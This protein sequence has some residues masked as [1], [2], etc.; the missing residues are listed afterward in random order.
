[1]TRL[2]LLASRLKPPAHQSPETEATASPLRVTP[3]P[4]LND[5]FSNQFVNLVEREKKQRV[6]VIYIVRPFFSEK[7]VSTVVGCL[8]QVCKDQGR[9]ISS[10]VAAATV[11]S[12]VFVHTWWT[13]A[14]NRKTSSHYH[15]ITA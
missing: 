13:I 8:H 3:A 10:A 14:N 9:F 5:F 4:V 6:V 12:C 11:C 15:L 7:P 1:M 2:E